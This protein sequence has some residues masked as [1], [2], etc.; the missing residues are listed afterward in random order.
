KGLFALL[1]VLSTHIVFGQTIGVSGTVKDEKGIPIPGV[2]VTVVGT[3]TG[4]ITNANGEYN[5]QAEKGDILKFSFLGFQSQT[6]VVS[7]KQV[8]NV[9]LKKGQA[10]D[11]VVIIGYGT[12]SRLDNTSAISTVS[13]EE[14]SKTKVANP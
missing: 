7:D 10:L 5:I 12:R 3:E 11:E 14:L 9:T 2:A 4:A 1:F 13:S 8:I 6:I